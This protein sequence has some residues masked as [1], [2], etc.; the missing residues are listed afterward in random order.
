MQQ[1]LFDIGWSDERKCQ[2]CYKEEGTEKHRLYH[3]PEWHEIRREIPV[4]FRKWEQKAKTLKEWKWQGGI[5]MHPLSESQCNRGHFSMKK[6]GSPRSTRI[7]AYQQKASWAMLPRTALCWEERASGERVVGLW[8]SWIMMRRW[9]PCTGCLHTFLQEAFSRCF[10]YTAYI[11]S[12]N[13]VH[14]GHQN[15]LLVCPF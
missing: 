15:T 1:G 12:T 3:C 10:A 5:V 2:A 7:G 9:S 14:P 6:I 4:A 11:R 8:C 13:K